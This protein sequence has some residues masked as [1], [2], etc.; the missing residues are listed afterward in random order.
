MTREFLENLGLE[1]EV[2]DQIMKEHGKAI[3]SAKPQDYGEIKEENEQLKQRIGELE[4]TVEELKGYKDQLTE[5]D[6]LIKEYEL[7]NVK[8][9][10][11]VEA[12]IPLELANRLTGESEDELKRD[13]EM[14]SSFIARKQTLPLKDTEPKNDDDPY[15]KLLS[16]LEGE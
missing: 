7:K 8:Y 13:A 15:K 1:K 3:Q 4:G 2:I 5:K 10:I 16:G 14:L 9:R 11:A 12:G 6:N